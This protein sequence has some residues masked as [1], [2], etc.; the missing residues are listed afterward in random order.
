MCILSCLSTRLQADIVY[1]RTDVTGKT[2]E[3]ALSKT[4]GYLD[5]PT[6]RSVGLKRQNW[7]LQLLVTVIQ[8][9]VPTCAE[10]EI[11]ADVPRHSNVFTRI[12]K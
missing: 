5:L 8:F 2:Y 1:R 10:T 7:F 9:A 11:S 12:Y 6:F 4:E 3:R